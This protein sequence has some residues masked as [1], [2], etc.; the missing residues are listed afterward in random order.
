MEVYAYP[1]TFSAARGHRVY[2]QHPSH[3]IQEESNASVKTGPKK[4]QRE[5]AIKSVCKAAIGGHVHS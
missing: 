1:N 5:T 4:Q 2:K 3:K